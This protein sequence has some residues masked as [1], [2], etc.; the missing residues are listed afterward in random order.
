MMRFR[1]GWVLRMRWLWMMLIWVGWVPGVGGLWMMLIWVGVH[2][3]LWMPLGVVCRG[4]R[5]GVLVWGVGN[6]RWGLHSCNLI[7]I[8]RRQSNVASK[9]DLADSISDP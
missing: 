2:W 9:L 1:M 8:I 6:D 3:T 7:T 5:V 4:A